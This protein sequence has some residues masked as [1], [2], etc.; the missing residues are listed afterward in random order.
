VKNTPVAFLPRH[1]IHHTFSPSEI[2]A[3]A[4]IYALKSLG[5]NKIVS[6]SA[7]GSGQYAIRY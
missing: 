3:K 2:P 4:N 6:I 1:G 5:V 7:V